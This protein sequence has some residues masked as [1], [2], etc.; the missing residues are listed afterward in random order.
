MGI[1]KHND[2]YSDLIIGETLKINNNNNKRCL[3]FF[4][5]ISDNVKGKV[6][7]YAEIFRTVL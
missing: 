7:V 1:R 4:T 2:T 3:R 5:V 6:Q